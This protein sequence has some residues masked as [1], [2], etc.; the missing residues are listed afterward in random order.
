MI[1]A[2]PNRDNRKDQKRADLNHV[3]GNVYRRRACNTSVCDVRDPQRKQHC[4]HHLEHRSRVGGAHEV[5]IQRAN[6]VTAEDP[7]HCHHHTRIDPVV[8]GLSAGCDRTGLQAETLACF[9]P[10]ISVTEDAVEI[11][12]K[13]R[14]VVATVEIV[15][16]EH[17][18]VAIEGVVPSFKPVKM[19]DAQI[20]D[21][22]ERNVSGF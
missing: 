15:I 10:V 6:D 2:I 5:G 7:R 16:D 19:V 4:N 17:F 8:K 12:V 20:R 18:P 9:D 22:F 21:A 13:L 11:F 14:H 1:Q 3:N